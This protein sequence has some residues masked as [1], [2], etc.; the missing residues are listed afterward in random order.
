[1]PT[2]MEKTRSS[3]R[4]QPPTPDP[5]AMRRERRDRVSDALGKANQTFDYAGQR[6]T[7]SINAALQ[8][9]KFPKAARPWVAN[10][11]RA[12]ADP[13]FGITVFTPVRPPDLSLENHCSTIFNW[14]GKRE[15]AGGIRPTLARKLVLAEAALKNGATQYPDAPS[16]PAPA[17]IDP[18]ANDDEADKMLEQSHDEN[19]A[20][21]PDNEFR[22]GAT[23]VGHHTPKWPCR[24]ILGEDGVCQDH[25]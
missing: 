13:N 5:L 16:S 20:F 2:T 19:Q 11:Q 23:T 17:A 24:N 10:V 9:P 25:P 21:G 12:V 6:V 4:Q 15:R 3:T 18:P 8:D 22:C 1:M 14:A 7:D